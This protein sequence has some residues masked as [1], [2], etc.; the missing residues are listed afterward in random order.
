MFC[1]IV[2]GFALIMSH[3]GISLSVDTFKGWLLDTMLCKTVEGAAF[4][5]TVIAYSNM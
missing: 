2:E 1:K 3:G 5:K 4:I